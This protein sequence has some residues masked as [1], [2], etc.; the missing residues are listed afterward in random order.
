MLIL[1][2]KLYHDVNILLLIVYL[3]KQQLLSKSM[4]YMP[5]HMYL[6]LTWVY[7][8]STP[9]DWELSRYIVLAYRIIN[10]LT[11]MDALT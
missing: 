6:D 3:V 7:D 4:P 9:I 1:L 11:K 10:N 8:Y 5:T 2:R